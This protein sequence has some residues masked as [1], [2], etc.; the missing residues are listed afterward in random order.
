[1]ISVGESIAREP[2]EGSLDDPAF[3]EDDEAYGF[4]RPRHGVQ[5]PAERFVH[6]V[7]QAVAPV[8]RVGEATLSLLNDGFIR[9]NTKH[10]P[11]W[12]WRLAEWTTTESNKP[13]VSTARWVFAPGDLLASVAT[14]FAT[15]DRSAIDDRHRRCGLL[16][17]RLAGLGPQGV[18][19]QLDHALT[20][21]A[22]KVL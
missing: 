3:G 18:M 15:A 20:T 19:N 9:E 22:Q 6:P 16:A 17:G 2:S 5:Q 4:G 21:P 12:S 13:S 8:R 14:L 7:G 10:A 1:M 11:S